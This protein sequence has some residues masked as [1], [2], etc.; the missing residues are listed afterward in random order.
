MS[1]LNVIYGMHCDKV[2]HMNWSVIAFSCRKVCTLPVLLSLTCNRRQSIR[3]LLCAIIFEQ[4]ISNVFLCI[5]GDTIHLQ[6]AK[7]VISGVL[8]AQRICDV[9][10]CLDR[11]FG[12][13]FF[14]P[15][16]FV[17]DRRLITKAS[18]AV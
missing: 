6:Q 3:S 11:S 9:L 1:R 17:L 2:T 14:V 7:H 16:C 15:R 18:A 5:G 10:E 13:S 12:K 8:L 4:S